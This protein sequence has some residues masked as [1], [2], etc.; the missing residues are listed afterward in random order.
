MT[1]WNKIY[2][3]MNITGKDGFTFVTI[4]YVAWPGDKAEEF[5]KQFIPKSK[6]DDEFTIRRAVVDPLSAMRQ[7]LCSTM[8]STFCIGI[9][10]REQKSVF[11]IGARKPQD[12]FKLLLKNSDIKKTYTWSTDIRFSIRVAKED[13]YDFEKS[14]EGILPR[15]MA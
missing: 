6:H 10:S 2:T 14:Q 12:I 9:G 13:D 15:G 1:E 3:G 8:S 7:Y 5:I 4:P 11:Y